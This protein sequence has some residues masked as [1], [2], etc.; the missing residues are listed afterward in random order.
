MPNQRWLSSSR[1]SS[2]CPV[3]PSRWR[4]R[5]HP[6]SRESLSNGIITNY[7]REN[8]RR[9]DMV[10]GIGYDD[11]IGRAKDILNRLIDHDSLPPERRARSSTKRIK[12]TV[13]RHRE[14]RATRQGWRGWG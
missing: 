4:D 8:A 9:V 7:S 10:F 1:V 13:F 12:D 3:A 11:D 5:Q 14:V 2:R 6:V